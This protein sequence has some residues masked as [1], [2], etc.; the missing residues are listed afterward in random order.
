MAVKHGIHCYTPLL[1]SSVHTDKNV[2]Q[3]F[4]IW[5]HHSMKPITTDFE[6][7]S[8]VIGIPQLYLS[9]VMILLVQKHY[10][11][12]INFDIFGIF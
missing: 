3:K 4:Q 2:N 5:I 9:H 6:S 12:P 11:T 10:F 1:T 8:H 7:N